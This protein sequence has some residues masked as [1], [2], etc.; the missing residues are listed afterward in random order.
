MIPESH[1]GTKRPAGDYTYIYW[2][3]RPGPLCHPGSQGIL[4]L[5]RLKTLNQNGTT[6]PSHCDRLKTPGVDMTPALWARVFLWRWAL[7]LGAKMRGK[8]FTT[9]LILGDGECDEGQVWK[10]LCPPPI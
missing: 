5:E 10:A 2:A 7:A 6:L 1:H 8:D 3:R 4:P 9:Y